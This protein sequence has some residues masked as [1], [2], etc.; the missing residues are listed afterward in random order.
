MCETSVNWSTLT[1]T[2]DSWEDLRFYNMSVPVCCHICRLLIDLETTIVEKHLQFP[3]TSPPTNCAS[4]VEVC[5]YTNVIL[6]DIWFQ[7]NP[8]LVPR[9]HMT[10]SN[11][12]V[13]SS[14]SLAVW[15]AFSAVKDHLFRAEQSNFMLARAVDDLPSCGESTQS[16]PS[17]SYS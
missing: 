6:W 2:D 14:S 15:D 16:N 8:P 12:G 17:Y 7:N 9:E 1:S 13:P 10:P 11:L 3:P 4:C 5:F